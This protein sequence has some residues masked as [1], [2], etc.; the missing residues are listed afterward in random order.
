MGSEKNPGEN[1]HQGFFYSRSMTER[2]STGRR[3]I[4]GLLLPIT[5]GRGLL[6]VITLLLLR[7][8]IGL[9]L[10]LIARLTVSLTGYTTPGCAQQTADGRTL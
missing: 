1:P 2:R 4:I 9:R 8:V 3:P 10:I 7:R 5:L 6:L